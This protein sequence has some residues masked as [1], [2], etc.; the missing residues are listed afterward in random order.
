MQD[1]TISSF[2][3]EIKPLNQK[4]NAI[5]LFGSRARQDFRPDSDYD[6]LVVTKEKDLSL[7]DRLIESAFD[8]LLKTGL[9]ISLKVFPQAEFK[10]LSNIP[11]PFMGNVLKE[12]I[13]IG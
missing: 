4:I 13:K 7:K 9:Y 3:A 1:E 5:Y 12:G 2:L 8:T 10:R 6:V 11:T